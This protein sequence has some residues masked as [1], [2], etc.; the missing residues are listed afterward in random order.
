MQLVMDMKLQKKY[1][2]KIIEINI[3][4]SNY[5]NTITDIFLKGKA[6]EVMQKLLVTIKS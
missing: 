6:T 5:T 2:K 1:N 4:S 3:Q